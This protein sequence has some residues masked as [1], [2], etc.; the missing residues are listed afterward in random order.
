MK[1]IYGID[2]GTIHSALAVIEYDNPLNVVYKAWKLN[3]EIEDYLTWEFNKDDVFGVEWVANY[4]R[5]V[6]EEVLR[7]AYAAGRFS[8]LAEQKGSSKVLQPTRPMINKHFCGT[9]SVPKQHCRQALLDKWGGKKAK[10]KGGALYPI[11][12]HIWDALAVALY[13]KEK[14][15]EQRTLGT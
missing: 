5:V 9:G 10:L 3:S 8:V 13:A 12:N 14:I 2:P 6:G 15:D 4:G 11:S 7:T 1:L